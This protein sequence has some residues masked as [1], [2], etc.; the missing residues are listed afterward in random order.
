MPLRILLIEDSDDARQL[1][2]WMLEL[3]GH[4]VVAAAD[5]RAGIASV[6]DVLP[7]VAI[8]DISLPDMTGY[9]VSRQIR[10]TN[11][12][13]KIV[14]IAMTGYSAPDDRVRAIDAGFDLHLVKPVDP[15]DLIAL[16][17]GCAAG[18]VGHALRLRRYL[19]SA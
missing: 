16:L 15:D 8:V 13:S 17:A 10:A 9:D 12:G 3:E 2:Q 18:G 11:H 4:E 5:G 6:R 14:I 19:L 7:D 1:L